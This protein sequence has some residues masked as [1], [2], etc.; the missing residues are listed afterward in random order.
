LLPAGDGGKISRYPYFCRCLEV[1]KLYGESLLLTAALFVFVI[2]ST[3]AQNAIS[4]GTIT[5]GVRDRAGGIVP[6]A[7]VTVSSDET[8][9]EFNA[10]T[11]SDGLY[12]FPVMMVGRYTLR[13]HDAG[14]AMS[15][16]L[17]GL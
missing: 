4:T 10:T 1:P 2:A 11:N 5:G 6:G 13:E 14:I 12:N 7:A 8:G 16:P 17:L 9:M 3:F 15:F